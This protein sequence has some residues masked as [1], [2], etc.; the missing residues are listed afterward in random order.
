MYHFLA[1]S[2]LLLYKAI[3]KHYERAEKER[4]R[5]R[6]EEEFLKIPFKMLNYQNNTKAK[7][8]H[9]QEKLITRK[10]NK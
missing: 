2:F 6:D 10:L 4:Q 1:K 9:I 8:I 7:N 5:K 3:F